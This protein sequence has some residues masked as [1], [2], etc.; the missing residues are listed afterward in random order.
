MF[1]KWQHSEKDCQAVGIEC[2]F[3]YIRGAYRFLNIRMLKSSCGIL[4]FCRTFRRY[5]FPTTFENVIFPPNGEYLLPPMPPE[6]TYSAERGEKKFKTTKRMIEGRGVEEVHTELIHNQYGLAAVYGGF[7]SSADFNF[8]QERV[9]KNLRKNQFALWR[10]PAPWLPRTK[11]SQGTKHG[12]GKGSIHMYYT[13]VRAKRIILE[14]GGYITEIEAQAFLLYLCERF[15]FPVEFISADILAKRREEEKRIAELN[16][17]QFNWEM[18]MKYNMQNCRSW[19]NEYDVA[20][21]GKWCVYV[22]GGLP[23]S[24]LFI[25]V[26]LAL[27]LHPA[28]ST[29]THCNVY[30]WLPSISAAV[31]AY[32]PERYVWRFFIGLHA[33]PRFIVAF[34]YRNLLLN[35]PMREYWTT[36]GW[37][38]LAC[39]LACSINL[40]ENAFLLLLTSVSSTEDHSLHKISFLGFALCAMAYM[41]IATTLYHFSGRRRASTVGEKSYQYKFL[42]CVASTVSLLSALYFFYRH[43]KSQSYSCIDCNTAFSINTYK[44][45]VKCISEDEKY[46][47]KNF[48]PK[49]SKGEVKQSRWVEQVERAISNVTDRELKGLLQ[50]IE[51]FANIPRKEAKFI[52]FLQNSIRIRD[53]ELCLRAWRCIDEEAKKM[54]AETEGAQAETSDVNEKCEK[55][56]DKNGESGEPASEGG[57]DEGD[58][59]DDD[60]P[61]VPVEKNFKWRK[62]IKRA[63]K[64]SEDGTMKVKKLRKAVVKMFHDEGFEVGVEKLDELFDQKLKSSGVLIEGKFARLPP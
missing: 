6:P 8:I 56:V 42:M 41:Y 61:V 9:N 21:K 4:L 10:V 18:V 63:L 20:W 12:G 24:A 30:N 2:F 44:S 22:V 29:S 51:G 64:A 54:K 60:K 38:P 50:Q 23:L 32:S 62:A 46:G 31:A 36:Q 59:R 57:N 28:Q 55:V 25:C 14:V 1:V 13:P 27:I 16:T 11:K 26:S 15:K 37:F 45:H 49:E 35:S 17:N 33:A 3:Q 19:L 53:R 47:G 40:A 5:S 48:V 43:N 7:I 52:N 58:K 39:N 34:A